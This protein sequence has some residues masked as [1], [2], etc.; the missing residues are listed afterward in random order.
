[1]L[2]GPEKRRLIILTVLRVC[3][4]L[5]DLLGLLGIAALAIAFGAFASSDGGV[6]S[7]ELSNF[8]A[9]IIGE[10]QAV[11]LAV[12]V[13]L[14]FI[15]KSLFSIWLKAKSALF[16]AKIETRLSH[17]LATSF[18]HSSQFSETK[19]SLSNFQTSALESTAGIRIHI[20]GLI[21]IISEGSLLFLVLVVFLVVNPIATVGL[22]VF[23]GVM[24]ICLNKL[25]SIHMSKNAADQ[26]DGSRESLTIARDLHGIK[27]EAL[28][29]GAMG[30]WIDRFE[31]ARGKFARANAMI[32]TLNSLPRF[33]IET[34]L[35]L[36][37]LFFLSAVVVFSDISSQ[38]V[39]IGVFL[40]GGLRVMASV[41][42]LQAAISATREGGA[43]GKLSLEE[44]GR[45]R[46]SRLDSQGVE[47]VNP[48]RLELVSVSYRHNS[49]SE[50]TLNNIS[51]A[52][53]PNTK[54]AIVGRSGSGKTT[55][56][57]ILSGYIPPDRGQALFG[58]KKT[59][60]VL[61]SEPGTF[62]VVPQRPHVVTGTLLENITL[63][64]QAASDKERA[65]EVLHRV[66]LGKMAS[67]PGW[68]SI[69]VAPDSAQL[70]GGEL[71]R[72]SIAR[73]IYQRPEILFLDEATSAM[74]AETE[75]QITKL[76]DELKKQM[77][78]VQVAHSLSVVKGADMLIYL[79]KGKV[80]TAE[81]FKDLSARIPAFAN[82]VEIWDLGAED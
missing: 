34:T 56:M 74:D 47:R 29:S 2:Q 11:L 75:L 4:N 20:N 73:A 81:S 63:V 72:L 23:M 59:R 28:S 46:E 65:L 10:V 32:Y 12:A 19:H 48:G 71:Q 82:A 35:I 36:S 9:I 24:L 49:S 13:T 26:I 42:P 51:L 3:A 69:Q 60:S 39:T 45:I 38:S 21:S 44:L 1:M 67:R 40:A 8:G 22:F 37:V 76:T 31:Q 16:V 18:F 52:I 41:L 64:N 68:H 58:G 55:L 80:T 77:T 30:F 15:V 79:D 70:S 14:V 66:G 33:V 17:R 54:V 61:M 6:A 43:L 5:L 25:I 50:L 7:I 57:E 62:G 27:R 53:E 78:V